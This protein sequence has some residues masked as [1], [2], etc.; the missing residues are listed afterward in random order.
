[1]LFYWLRLRYCIYAYTPPKGFRKICPAPIVIMLPLRCSSTDYST[2]ITLIIS[3]VNDCQWKYDLRVYTINVFSWYAITLS[4]FNWEVYFQVL[5]SYH[6][7]RRK[8]ITQTNA[9]PVHWRIFGTRGRWINDSF[10]FI[11]RDFLYSAACPQH[12]NTQFLLL[13]NINIGSFLQATLFRGPFTDI[14]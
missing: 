10:R 3:C 2:E 1:M 12:F 13:S 4:E 7:T 8:A 11:C 14:D 5:S 9:D 6:S